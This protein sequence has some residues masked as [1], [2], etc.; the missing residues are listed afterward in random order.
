MSSKLKKVDSP[1]SVGDANSLVPK[2]G[3]WYW[4]KN[5]D[6]S[7]KPWFGC[8]VHVGTN[9]VEFRGLQR[10]NSYSTTRVHF[11]EI[12]ST[13]TK[14]QDPDALIAEKIDYY[15][16]RVMKLLGKVKTLTAELSAVPREELPE[17][18]D[19]N[20]LV[21]FNQ[22]LDVAGYKAALIKAQEETIPDLFKQIKK[23]N[24]H[25][26]S[27]MSAKVIPYE[28]S[29]DTQK[30][31]AETI[32]DRIFSIELYAG[33]I[34]EAVTICDGE[35][36]DSD[37]KV[38]LMQRRCYMD[39]ECLAH[40]RTGGMEFKHLEEF[41]TWL[42]ESENLDRLLPFPRC[43]ISFR[44]RRL[45]KD[46]P[47][48]SYTDFVRVS[49]L[50]EL[51]ERTFIYI[52]NG[53]QLHRV[54]TSYDFGDDLY[55][56]LDDLRVAGQAWAHKDTYKVISH[57]EWLAIRQEDINSNHRYRQARREFRRDVALG[58]KSED[59]EWVHL[60][61]L[62]PDYYESKRY[63]PFDTSTVYYDDIIKGVSANIQHHNRLVLILQG[64]LDR[65]KLLHPHPSYSLWTEA[66]FNGALE[67]VFDRTR[68]LVSGAAP[69]FAAYVVELNRQLKTGS[70]TIGQEAVWLELERN[71][72]QKR[73]YESRC[74]SD[75]WRPYNN[76]GPGYLAKVVKMSKR[77]RICRYEW[78]RERLRQKPFARPSDRE[79]IDVSI[80][81]PHDK[82]FNVSAYTPGDYKR[83]FADPR[84]RQDY[85]KWAPILL[86]AE[87]Y[88]AG[89]WDLADG[90][91]QKNFRKDNDE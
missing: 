65:S 37:A 13:L 3:E 4:I 15:Q 69:D 50:R 2:K 59:S 60:R 79:H 90:F 85:L 7:E 89:N 28:V 43:I 1:V 70:I 18:T 64:L 74:V 77:S 83:F 39:E 32:K 40:Y 45:H 49:K 88:H 20:A 66:G 56:D 35:P 14:E 41:D 25:L 81:V 68:A 33:L 73:R 31:I 22:S 16:T 72:E 38:H 23:A 82:L 36:A 26:A 54:S 71:R 84:T 67:L 24:E 17:T 9:Y 8:C 6:R 76:S 46:R 63:I 21:V 55:P 61:H 48:E 29:S 10:T 42:A 30:Q 52:R 80:S 11:D 34:E 87:E 27:W 53:A 12:L 51:D 57:N 75:Y 5:H 58:K 62:R 91:N 47:A 78:Q 44:V 86:A 19:N